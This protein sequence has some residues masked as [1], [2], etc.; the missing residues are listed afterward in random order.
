V[1]HFEKGMRTT[2]YDLCKHAY[3]NYPSVPEAAIER[4]SWLWAYAA[5]VVIAIDQVMWTQSVTKALR[6]I[7]GTD[8]STEAA[9]PEA[10]INFY[11]FSLQQIGAM[12]NLVRTP[13]DKQQ[14]GSIGQPF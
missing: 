14:V 6:R 13:L 7:E 1:Q 5:Q 10:M 11:E 9:D 3:R 12:V 2:L 8:S 4:K